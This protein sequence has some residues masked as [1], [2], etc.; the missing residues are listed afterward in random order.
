MNKVTIV[1][2]PDDILQDG[3]RI[4]AYDLTA[5][6]NNTV[7]QAL[8][9]VENDVIVYHYEYHYHYLQQMILKIYELRYY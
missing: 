7:S 9:E 8:R 4:L 3:T 5:T 1:T 6:Q 2:P